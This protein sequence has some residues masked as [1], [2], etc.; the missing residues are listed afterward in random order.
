MCK[1][2]C[3][4]AYVGILIEKLGFFFMGHVKGHLLST[5]KRKLKIILKNKFFHF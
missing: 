2:P 4:S 3:F 1:I 5:P